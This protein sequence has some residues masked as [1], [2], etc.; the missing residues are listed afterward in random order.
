MLAI[1]LGCAGM[2]TGVGNQ[3]G[4]QNIEAAVKRHLPELW[5]LGEDAQDDY[6]D[7]V[8]S[9]NDLK[10]ALGPQKAARDDEYK[11]RVRRAERMNEVLL[12]LQRASKIIFEAD[13][14][15]QTGSSGVSGR[16]EL[17]DEM[18]RAVERARAIMDQSR[19]ALERLELD[20]DGISPTDVR[21]LKEGLSTEPE[22]N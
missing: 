7:V 2:C 17:Q 16:D 20:F 5:Q 19:E 8:Q 13:A 10:V 6:A 18:T 3:T 22:P 4:T 1:L 15:F 12:D 14:K 21:K 11:F 9:A